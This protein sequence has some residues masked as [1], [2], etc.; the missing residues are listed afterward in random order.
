[1]KRLLQLLLVS[2]SMGCAF[3][4]EGSETNAIPQ[5][6]R[7]KDR[8]ALYYQAEMKNDMRTWYGMKTPEF[9]RTKTY[10]ECIRGFFVDENE[11]LVS[12]RPLHFETA[13]SLEDKKDKRPVVRIVMEIVGKRKDDHGQWTNWTRNDVHEYWVLDGNEWYQMCTTVP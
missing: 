9:R 11:K 5:L 2:A 3:P 6:A 8:I 13:Q 12:W 7:L 10:E 4:V 1:M